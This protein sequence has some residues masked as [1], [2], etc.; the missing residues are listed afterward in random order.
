MPEKNINKAIKR[1]G[2]IIDLWLPLKIQYDKI[3]GMSVGIVHKGK[4]VYKRGFGFADLKKKVKASEKT[5]YHIASHSKMFTAV[6]VMKLVERSMLRL[7][8]KV[9]DYLDWFKVREGNKDSRDITVRQLLSHTAGVFRDGVTGFWSTG[10]FPQEIQS[11][12]ADEPLARPVL[13]DFKYTNYG[14]ALLGALVEKVSGEKYSEFLE[15]EIIKPLKL[16]HT[17][18]DYR[19]DTADVATGYSGEFPDRSRKAFG[20]IKARAY[21]SATGFVSSVEDMA[22][23][24]SQFSLKHEGDN[25][26]SLN[27]KREMMYPI[28]QTDQNEFYGLGLDIMKIKDHKIIGHG[29]GYPGFITRTIFDPELELGIIVFSNS[30]GSSGPMVS[31]GILDMVYTFA[32]EKEGRRDLSTCEGIFCDDWG[33]S[34][35]VSK[36]DNLIFFGVQSNYPTKSK[37]SLVPGKRK[38]EFT[39][40]TESKFYPGD[41]RVIFRKFKN[42]KYHEFLWSGSLMKRI[43]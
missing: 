3:P 2:E 1:T 17:T 35:I 18:V 41:E 6:A 9:A 16:K 26:L 32:D 27:S 36:G 11:T 19:N 24:I 39:A 4:L 20:H 42:G 14:Y 23:F 10:I 7:D 8:D 43:R 37:N 29:G 28:A 34:V 15:K 31:E 25:F 40:K 5:L 38:G 33:D 12:V 13:A 30:L 21:A 22:R